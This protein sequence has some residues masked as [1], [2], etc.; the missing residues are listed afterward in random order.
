MLIQG[1]PA[2]PAGYY[3]VST[4]LNQLSD[5]LSTSLKRGTDVHFYLVASPF[6][7]TVRPSFYS[8]VIGLQGGST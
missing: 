5:V 3:S 2:R 1:P 6:L 7:L 4:S 8:W